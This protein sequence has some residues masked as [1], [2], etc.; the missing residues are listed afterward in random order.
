[1]PEGIYRIR[2]RRLAST[3]KPAQS[4]VPLS[5]AKLA[6]ASLPG[7]FRRQA[8]DFLDK[9]ATMN[10]APLTPH[11][12]DRRNAKVDATAVTKLRRFV[13]SQKNSRQYI[14]QKN[15][16]I[17]LEKLRGFRAKAPRER[18]A[19]LG[20]EDI[21]SAARKAAKV[22]ELPKGQRY[23]S[24]TGE[25]LEQLAQQIDQAGESAGRMQ[26]GPV[27]GWVGRQATA[28]INP[29]HTTEDFY[30]L[31]ESGYRDQKNPEG[32]SAL[33]FIGSGVN[34]WLGIG[35]PGAGRLLAPVGKAVKPLVTSAGARVAQGVAK[36][37]VKNQA[38]SFVEWLRT[39]PAALDHLSKSYMDEGLSE[40]DSGAKAL[41]LK[42]TVAQVS[43][44]DIEL[45][46]SRVPVSRLALPGPARQPGLPSRATAVEPPA[47]IVAGDIL[48]GG[49]DA[50]RVAADR[51]GVGQRKYIEDN[52]RSLAEEAIRRF[53]N[54]KD[55]LRI[56]AR[57][58]LKEAL[59]LNRP[60]RQL[61]ETLADE[62]QQKSGLPRV[63]LSGYDEPAQVAQ[64]IPPGGYVTQAD[65]L[66]EGP[67][68]STAP[69]VQEPVSTG[70]TI[71]SAAKEPTPSA[72]SEAFAPRHSD[73]EK[74]RDEFDIGPRDKSVKSDDELFSQADSVDDPLSLARESN[75]NGRILEDFEEL[76][77][78]GKVQST[79]S[80]LSSLQDE[81]LAA[82]DDAAKVG[83][84]SRIAVLEDDL[85]Q[86]AEAL[87]RTGT[88]LG[89]GQR[90][91]SIVAEAINGGWDESGIKYRYSKLAGEPKG[92]PAAKIAEQARTIKSLNKQIEKLK[93]TAGSKEFTERIGAAVRRARV[94]RKRVISEE[95]RNSALRRLRSS[96]Q[97]SRLS[98]STTIPSDI[99]DLATVIAFDIESG[100]RS[101]PELYASV[102]K[103]IPDATDADINI[104][105][106]HALDSV[107]KKTKTATKAANKT[108]GSLKKEVNASLS[109]DDLRRAN[110][111]IDTIEKTLKDP[112]STLKQ[113][114]DAWTELTKIRSKY[115][116][117]ADVGIDTLI[118]GQVAY[119]ADEISELRY[120]LDRVKQETLHDAM[121]AKR[122]AE[123]EA[124]NTIGKIV[125]VIKTVG[126]EPSRLTG[127]LAATVD[128]SYTGRQGLWFNANVLYAKE[129]SRAFKGMLN[130][131]K[132]RKGYE[133]ASYYIRE[134]P[135]YQRAKQDGVIFEGEEFGA[136]NAE[137]FQS[138]LLSKLE[139][140]TLK[141]NIRGPVQ[142][143]GEAYQMAG[144]LQR[145]ES[146]AKIVSGAEQFG[147]AVDGDLGSRIA[148]YVNIGTGRG[149][150]FPTKAL[151]SISDAVLGGLWSPKLNG[152]RF[153]L[154]TGMPL[155][156]EAYKGA[157]TGDYRLARVIGRDYIAF[158]SMMSAI[159]GVAKLAGA[160]VNVLNYNDPDWGKIKVG[161]LHIDILGGLQQVARFMMRGKDAIL[162]SM[163]GED[164]PY[165][166]DLAGLS[167]D[168]LRKKASPLHGE[169]ANW[170]VYGKTN[171][172]GK[173][174]TPLSSAEA[175]GTPLSLRGTYSEEAKEYPAESTIATILNQVGVGA[176]VY[177]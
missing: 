177:D 60:T 92:K 25:Y 22:P 44:G 124:A 43:P 112:S 120:K 77:V 154:V 1:M 102:R 26:G 67:K 110:A 35:A 79:R 57:E 42:R 132:T 137:M 81:L 83:I 6:F 113:M 99:L 58:E 49:D 73:V 128:I 145:I 105:T 129:N 96:R 149:Q 93:E 123:F 17:A 150:F 175:L 7:E 20:L 32:T 24:T 95:A 87:D 52:W 94:P 152:S 63:P 122:K 163:Y 72:S 100:I 161:P 144:N 121:A 4:F 141:K 19:E 159:F 90:A 119:K 173:P 47:E 18:W 36:S 156:R 97:R 130:S 139:K 80:A 108:I 34:V 174:V 33:D 109:G 40:I 30:F 29:V 88:K 27:G 66:I 167:E 134:H 75:N 153:E 78:A 15:Y 62:Y 11:N 126:R 74:L 91:R 101:L 9:V 50:A 116:R 136:E 117:G 51:A 41:Q 168:F 162:R 55:P 45:V 46:F 28:A 86:M 172:I 70:P 135:Y 158:G 143:S 85:L 146:Y 65:E 131:L 176:S 157:L 61:A 140:W 14:E 10:G 118:Q 23:A 114:D 127:Q 170:F 64:P 82:T 68:A 12:I 39:D 147:K 160:E 98:G 38:A 16:E 107:L 84:Q 54:S 69:K 165:E 151:Q 59:R 21:E 155:I 71:P 13:D 138:A 171:P 148:E 56:R 37:P 169:I 142:A 115:N 48:R 31:G 164:Q 53:S 2:Q 103:T 125:Q 111:A 3:E 89:R 106:K 76:S 166:G 104:A 5:E 8:Y 133:E